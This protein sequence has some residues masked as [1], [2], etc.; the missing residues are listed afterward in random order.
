MV[1]VKNL[2]GTS[3]NPPPAGCSS[4]REFWEEKQVWPFE[5]CSCKGCTRDAEHGAHVQKA[6]STDRK[7]YIVPLCA[8]CN[9]GK[10]DTEFEV[11]EDDLVAVDS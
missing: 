10:K 3:D 7:W 11:D 8:K 9:I 1:K 4:W 2:K 5:T 6:D